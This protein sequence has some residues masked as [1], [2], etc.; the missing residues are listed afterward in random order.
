MAKLVLKQSVKAHGPL[1]IYLEL[2]FRNEVQK[3]RQRLRAYLKI[4]I[5][6]VTL[7]GISISTYA[8]KHCLHHI[9]STGVA[10]TLQA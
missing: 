1:V 2:K 6:L 9:H 5:P 4:E 10:Y 8:L 3:M 7:K